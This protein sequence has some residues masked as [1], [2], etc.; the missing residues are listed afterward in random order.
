MKLKLLFA[1]FLTFFA[2]MASAQEWT[3]SG[4]TKISGSV[5]G[6]ITKGYFF[7]TNDGGFYEITEK[8]KQKV[9]EKN[10]DV[11]IYKNG[12]GYKLI[13]AGFKDT[14]ICRKV[15]DVIETKI[16]GDFTGWDGST[17]FKLI[18]GHVWQQDSYSTLTHNSYRPTVYIYESNKAMKM[19]VEDIDEVI[20]V[21]RLR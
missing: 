16:D 21:K 17:V 18:D 4:I 10:P 7:K 20:S 13:I 19:K 12:D 15:T 2:L 8:T 1:S 11:T 5:S 6:T 3:I 9:R 14:V